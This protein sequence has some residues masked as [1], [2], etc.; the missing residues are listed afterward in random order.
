[1]ALCATRGCWPPSSNLHVGLRSPRAFPRYFS[2]S[3]LAHPQLAANR[4]RSPRPLV[5]RSPPRAWGTGTARLYWRPFAIITFIRCSP[6]RLHRNLSRAA[7]CF[8]SGAQYRLRFEAVLM[9][10]LITS[11]PQHVLVEFKGSPHPLDELRQF[12]RNFADTMLVT[13]S[14]VGLP[15]CRLPLIS[16]GGPRSPPL[17]E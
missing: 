8:S 5:A 14:V 11:R 6:N 2:G 12:R 15:T 7:W 3:K 17:D 13:L 16:F 9:A 1:M 4:N 10:S